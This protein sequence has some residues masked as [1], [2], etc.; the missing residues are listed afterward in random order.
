MDPSPVFQIEILLIFFYF[1]TFPFN[2]CF[3]NPFRIQPTRILSCLIVFLILRIINQRDHLIVKSARI[4]SQILTEILYTEIVFV[5]SV[6]QGVGYFTDLIRFPAYSSIRFLL[7]WILII[8]YVEINKVELNWILSW[9]PY[10]SLS[11]PKKIMCL[12]ISAHLS[13]Y[14]SQPIPTTPTVSLLQYMLSPCLALL[15]GMG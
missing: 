7:F 5:S 13:A 11:K 15:D 3:K 10:P 14:T 12:Y 4:V 2:F 1:F 9:L 6:S 8:V